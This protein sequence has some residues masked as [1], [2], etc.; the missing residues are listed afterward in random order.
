MSVELKSKS[1]PDCIGLR[2][3]SDSSKTVN[4]RNVLLSEDTSTCTTSPL[5]TERQAAIGNKT[6]IYHGQI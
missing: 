3:T 6:W 2:V 1:V 5:L 4:V